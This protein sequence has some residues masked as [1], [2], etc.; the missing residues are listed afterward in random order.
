MEIIKQFIYEVATD[1]RNGPLSLILKA[2]L[3]VLSGFYYLVAKIRIAIYEKFY[4]DKKFLAKPVISIGN[5]TVG[6]SGKTPIVELVVRILQEKKLK[7]VI[8]TRGYMANKKLTLRKYSDEANMLRNS[9]SGVEVIVGAARF[10]N[11]QKYLRHYAADIF[12][13]DDGFQ[14]FQLARELDIVA[15]DC[16]NPFGNGFLLPRG[17]LREPVESL[18]RAHLFILT[19]SDIGRVNVGRIK[20]TIARVNPKADIVEA[21]H[22]PVEF[23][24]LGA[25]KSIE[26]DSLKGK[27]VGVFCS[28]ADPSSF[29][30]TL[31]NQGCL[32]GFKKF[33]LDHHFYQ[34]SEIEN[35]INSC[36]KNKIKYLI[37]TEKDATKLTDLAKNIALRDLKILYLRITI[38]IIEGEGKLID[39]INNI[40]LR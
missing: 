31:I 24:E 12:V 10:L 3:L 27:K 18:R 7:P 38:K 23:I 36:E 8:L 4:V 22:S 1:K 15:I 16:T 32:I 9:L 26:L 33:F 6:G 35:V 20:E 28:I 30:K 25:N 2:I 37:T 17:I 5:I 19:K 11:A 40:P 13:L 34:K 29:E 39:R 21:I 14:H